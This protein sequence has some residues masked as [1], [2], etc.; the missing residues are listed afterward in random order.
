MSNHATAQRMCNSCTLDG[1]G[2]YNL[3]LVALGIFGGLIVGG[4]GGHAVVVFCCLCI[5]GAALV[6]V[7][8]GAKYARAAAMQ[9]TFA[10]V[11][12]VLDAVL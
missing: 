12:L 4:S 3:F 2:F 8:G 5:V 9:G 10:L 6:L 7:S 1:N 11:A